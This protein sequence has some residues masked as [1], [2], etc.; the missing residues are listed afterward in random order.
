[1]C[2]TCA[3]PHPEAARRPLWRA[4]ITW[5]LALA[6]AASAVLLFAAPPKDGNGDA[7]S[8]K[9]AGNR[10]DEV[11]TRDRRQAA[12][13]GAELA[14]GAVKSAQRDDVRAYARRYLAYEQDLVPS[15]APSPAPTADHGRPSDARLLNA[16]T[17]HSEEDLVI[18]RIE[19]EDGRTPAARAIAAAM[20][21]QERD[22]LT[23][24]RALRAHASS[25][26]RSLG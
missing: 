1:M 18:A 6:V 15:V 19:L 24:L 25:R 22:N 5:W 8:A 13:A 26:P 23:R 16:L 14:A 9:P 10:T 17:R 20:T 4:P 7:R 21:R 3:V 11:F 2:E 12:V